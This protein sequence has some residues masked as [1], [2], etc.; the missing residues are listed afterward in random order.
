MIRFKCAIKATGLALAMSLGLSSPLAAQELIGAYVAYIGKAD[1]VNSKGGR[2][3][4][5]WQV[6]RQDRAN[7][8]R[9]G[10]SQPG[11]EWDPFFGSINNRK[12]M[13]RMVRNGTIDP[14]A[15]N[16]LMNGNATVFVRIFG[17]GNTGTSVQVTVTR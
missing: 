8:H 2:L 1:L 17:S 13:E 11:D 15:A 14:K 10:V 12:I 4:A 6:L 3:S 16:L 9:F 7:Y 5:P